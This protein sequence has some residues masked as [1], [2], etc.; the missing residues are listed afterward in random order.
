MK[1]FSK[2]KRVHRT[3]Q[4]TETRECKNCKRGIRVGR[5]VPSVSHFK[6]VNGE[7]A[8]F[9]QDFYHPDCYT[10]TF[11]KQVKYASNKD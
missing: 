7:S 2:F 3:V 9:K 11:R 4:V 6:V 8:R 5:R 1:T 10:R